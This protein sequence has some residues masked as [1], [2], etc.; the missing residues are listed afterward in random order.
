MKWYTECTEWYLGICAN[1][2]YTDYGSENESDFI[3]IYIFFILTT[4]RGL[5]VFAFWFKIS[6]TC[7]IQSK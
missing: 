2:Y 4:G 6:R 7:K 3:S 5:D 1:Y